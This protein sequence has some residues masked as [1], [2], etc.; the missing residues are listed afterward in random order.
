MFFVLV[1]FCDNGTTNNLLLLLHEKKQQKQK[2]HLK[3]Y[4][5]NQFY[6]GQ[7]VAMRFYSTN[8]ALLYTEISVFVIFVL[9]ILIE[10]DEKFIQI[11]A[12]C[13]KRNVP[14]REFQQ[15]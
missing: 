7:F 15:K 11:I 10:A 12:S 13:L 3:L 1:L 6:N 4:S 14:L 9:I 8:A 5:E 2:L